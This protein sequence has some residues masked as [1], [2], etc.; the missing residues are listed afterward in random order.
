MIFCKAHPKSVNRVSEA[1][2]YFKEVFGLIVNEDKSLIYFA[3]IDDE[4]K[5]II[6]GKMGFK[7]GSLPMRYL[8]VSLAP[9]KWKASDCQVLFDKIIRRITH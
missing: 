8:G 4:M 7:I 2:V 9:C 5:T 6:A 1:L 3:G